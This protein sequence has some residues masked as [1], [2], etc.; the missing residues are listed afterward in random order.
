V[1]PKVYLLDKAIAYHEE[2]KALQTTK[3]ELITKVSTG[4]T[5]KMTAA[6]NTYEATDKLMVASRD[7]VAK[8][9][10]DTA[11]FEEAMKNLEY[12]KVVE[13]R[14]NVNYQ[15]ITSDMDAQQKAVVALIGDVSK[16]LTKSLADARGV[17]GASVAA[18]LLKKT[19]DADT[20]QKGAKKLYVA[21]IAE[22]K[23][24]ASAMSTKLIAL[25][26]LLGEAKALDDGA[27]KTA[28]GD[29]DKWLAL[30][31]TQAKDVAAKEVIK[32]AKIVECEA[33]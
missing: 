14:E 9:I 21:Q 15:K 18:G 4:L 11:V 28:Q 22:A 12:K 13:D 23:K 3:D 20:K 27:V 29:Y 6:K 25:E 16:G 5:A 19:A 26:K 32:V 2:A 10:A 31:V 1:Y 24:T 8:Y 17:L 7:K 30:Q 33:L